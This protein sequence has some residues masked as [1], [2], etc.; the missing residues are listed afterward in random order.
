MYNRLGIFVNFSLQKSRSRCFFVWVHSITRLNVLSNKKYVLV[1]CF[2]LLFNYIQITRSAWNHRL[3]ENYYVVLKLGPKYR[4]NTNSCN[5][6]LT[7]FSV[8]TSVYVKV[9][10]GRSSPWRSRWCPWCTPASGP[11]ATSSTLSYTSWRR[12]SPPH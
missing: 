8:L 4:K 12:R 9:C 10:Y 7:V 1:F 2:G 6:L 3:S 11:Q 5:F